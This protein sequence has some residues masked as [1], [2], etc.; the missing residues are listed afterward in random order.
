MISKMLRPVLNGLDPLITRLFHINYYA[1]GDATWG[2]TTWMG[3]R[4]LKNP[5]DLWTYQEILSENRPDLIIECGT[6]KGG[7]AYYFAHLFDLL[8]NGRVI[9]IDI[10]EY[11]AKPLHPRIEYVLKSSTSPECMELVRSRIKPG[12]KVMVILDSDHS[13]AHVAKELSLYAPIVTRGQYMVVED[14]N[15]NGHPV[16]RGHGAG[17]ME[18]LLDFMKTN[19]DFEID[20]HRERFKLTFQPSGWLKRVR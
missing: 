17:P 4:I 16:S 13:Q 9:T 5:M 19:H 18:A 7:S 6:N 3:A 2:N 20:R 15:V 1:G 12:E 8:D 14:T 11:P 10:A